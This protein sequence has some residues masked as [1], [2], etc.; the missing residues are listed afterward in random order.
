MEAGVRKVRPIPSLV[1]MS[2]DPLRVRD[3]VPFWVD[4]K[5]RRGALQ[6]GLNRVGWRTVICVR[7]G[8]LGL[9]RKL[10]Q[11]VSQL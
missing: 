10:L 5:Y 6:T 4:G 3:L 11:T 9:R 2:V 7:F 1:E 8:I